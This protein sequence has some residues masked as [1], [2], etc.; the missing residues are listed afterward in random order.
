MWYH[1]NQPVKE[2]KDISIYQDTE[3]VCKLSINEVFPEDEGQYTC[4]AVNALGEAVC[5]TSLI[6]EGKII[7]STYKFLSV[8][9]KQ[10]NSMLQTIKNDS[11]LRERYFIVLCRANQKFFSAVIHG[12]Y[13]HSC[14]IH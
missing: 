12:R 13:F 3:G 8:R 2:S 9:E 6:V 1:N 14:G 11:E 4:E 7:F 10:A 5:A